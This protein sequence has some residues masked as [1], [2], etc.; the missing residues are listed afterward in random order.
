MDD[1]VEYRHPTLS[2]VWRVSSYVR[3][4]LTIRS[5]TVV[6]HL[7]VVVSIDDCWF[8]YVYLHIST[9]RWYYWGLVCWWWCILPC[10]C[11][12]IPIRK[13]TTLLFLAYTINW[14]ILLIVLYDGIMLV[15][16]TWY[17]DD[18]VN[19]ISWWWYHVAISI[20]CRVRWTMYSRMGTIRM[21]II[22]LYIYVFYLGWC[23]FPSIP[24]FNSI[25]YLYLIWTIRSDSSSNSSIANC[26]C[27]L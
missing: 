3:R 2:I 12:S 27:H 5:T 1:T 23:L 11:P 6:V 16:M 13:I 26:H 9:I 25:P 10:S 4:I 15:G 7:L 18:S 8:L 21:I 14:V 24:P 22:P 19:T 20:V 17:T